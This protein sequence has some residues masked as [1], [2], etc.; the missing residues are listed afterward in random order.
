MTNN[1]DD[2][3]QPIGP[4]TPTTRVKDHWVILTN[5][6]GSDTSTKSP[7]DCSIGGDHRRPAPKG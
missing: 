7:C 2:D 4:V 1:D 5:A 3:T 6:D